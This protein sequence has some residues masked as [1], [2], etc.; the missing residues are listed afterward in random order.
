LGNEQLQHAIYE[1]QGHFDSCESEPAELTIPSQYF[2]YADS[3]VE[4]FFNFRED[5]TIAIISRTIYSQNKVL[6]W[7]D[8][9]FDA[10]NSKDIDQMP[11]PL[12]E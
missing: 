1:A 7:N 2:E 4:E 10:G 6:K 11:T 9:S 12:F 8:S 5:D 3:S